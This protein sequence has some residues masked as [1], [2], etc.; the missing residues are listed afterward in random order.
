LIHFALEL[1]NVLT[2]PVIAIA[3]TSQTSVLAEK[4][5]SILK[6][7]LH[8]VQLLSAVRLLSL[9]LDQ[10]R[11]HRMQLGASVHCFGTFYAFIQVLM[12][13]M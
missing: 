5:M 13:L 1:Q 2:N 10:P 4:T 8:F 11:P 12:Y 3:A 6:R 9:L 7:G